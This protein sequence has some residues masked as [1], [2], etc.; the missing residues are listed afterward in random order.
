MSEVP[1]EQ[2]AHGDVV[3]VRPGERVPVDGV[4]IEGETEVDEALLT[5]ESLPVAKRPGDAMIGGAING[6]GLVRLRATAVGA[7]STLARIIRLVENAQTGKAPVQRLVDRVSA[8]FVPV[9][10]AIAAI[11]FVG[12]M[13]TGGGFEAALAAAVSVLVIACP[14]ALGLATPTALVAGTG[15]GARAGIL[16]KDIEALERA[17]RV[18]TVVFDKTGTLTA[19]QAGGRRR[20][21][22]STKRRA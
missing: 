16:I 6:T 20:R 19:G 9:V 10:L 4:V 8:I 22:A 14:C 13:A 21:S 1:V 18:D 5:G 7:D 15:A 2:V 12:W 17:H 11:A 3:I